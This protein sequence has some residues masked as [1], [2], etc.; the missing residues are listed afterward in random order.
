MKHLL[1]IEKVFLVD[2]MKHTLLS[3]S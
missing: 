1:Y 2:G 3:I